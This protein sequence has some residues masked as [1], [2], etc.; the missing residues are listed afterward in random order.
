DGN[1]GLTAVRNG[2]GHRLDDEPARRFG[3]DDNGTSCA[4]ALLRSR[5]GESVARSIVARRRNISGKDSALPQPAREILPP[6]APS[7]TSTVKV[8]PERMIR[9]RS[10]GDRAAAAMGA[11]AGGVGSVEPLPPRPTAAQR[12]RGGT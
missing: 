4:H 9:E 6:P 3:I 1:D 5:G 10:L 12:A 2:L 7:P 11:G 8:G